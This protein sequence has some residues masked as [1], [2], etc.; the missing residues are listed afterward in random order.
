MQAFNILYLAGAPGGVGG[1][2]GA[3]RGAAHPVANAA[4]TEASISML[5]S[6][7]FMIVDV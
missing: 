2:G 3:C 5:N 6:F 1:F 7:F 4:T